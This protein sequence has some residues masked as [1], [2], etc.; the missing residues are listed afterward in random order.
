MGS[1]LPVVFVALSWVSHSNFLR[2]THDL[3][4]STTGRRYICHDLY[5]LQYLFNIILYVTVV[6]YFYPYGTHDLCT[7]T[8][9]S[10]THDLCTSSTGNRTDGLCISITDGEW[11]YTSSIRVSFFKYAEESRF[12]ERLDESQ[13]QKEFVQAQIRTSGRSTTNVHT[14][15]SVSFATHKVRMEHNSSGHLNFKNFLIKLIRRK[16][17]MIT[18]VRKLGR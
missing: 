6:S 13:M 12:T 9:G 18:L 1:S 15:G 16:G 14:D 17:R 11:I 10:R 5:A 4:T 8:T 2:E 7:S 3:C